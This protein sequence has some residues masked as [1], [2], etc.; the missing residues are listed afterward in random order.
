VVI[1]NGPW[2]KFA[3]EWLG[4]EVPVKPL[5]GQIVHLTPPA[6]LHKHAIFHASGYVLPKPSG[7]LIVGTTEED[8]GF[9]REPTL[10]GQDRIMETIVRLA[11]I[12]LNAPIKNVTACLRPLSL[13]G[14]PFIGRAPGWDDVYLA[15]GHG[16]KGI[17]QCLATGKYL[18][19][20]I[21]RGHSDYPLDPFSPQRLVATGKASS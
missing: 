16:S 10:E 18:A 2:S 9:Q 20:L 3:G 11:P 15:T 6:P 8:A 13:D 17:V 5:K 1:A 14:L 12:L 21:A 4:Y 19:Q 7:Q